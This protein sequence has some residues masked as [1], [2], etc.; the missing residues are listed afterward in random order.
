MREVYSWRNLPLLVGLIVAYQTGK[1]AG[2]EDSAVAAADIDEGM[3]D[4]LAPLLHGVTLEGVGVALPQ[5]RT[6]Y[7][8]KECDRAPYS[9]VQAE[10]SRLFRQ[11]R[12]I[13]YRQFLKFLPIIEF[14]FRRT[15]LRF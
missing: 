1:G 9:C 2:V 8:R 6:S 13:N 3:I 14:I 11:L 5:A 4:I 12:R 15:I 10:R 7:R